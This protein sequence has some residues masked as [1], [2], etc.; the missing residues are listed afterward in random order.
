MALEIGRLGSL[1]GGIIKRIVFFSFILLQLFCQNISEFNTHT[2]A[3]RSFSLHLRA[4]PQFP[5]PFSS[6]LSGASGVA[7]RASPVQAV[8]NPWAFPCPASTSQ[9]LVLKTK[10]AFP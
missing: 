7:S 6:I 2:V 1:F 9:L 3:V 5:G 4:A 10:R 8:A